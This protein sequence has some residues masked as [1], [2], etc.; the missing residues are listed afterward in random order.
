MTKLRIPRIRLW[1]LFAFVTLAA[2]LLGLWPKVSLEVDHKPGIGSRGAIGWNS[3]EP[4]ELWNT[5][6]LPPKPPPNLSR[7][8]PAHPSM[9]QWRRDQVRKLEPREKQQARLDEIRSRF[10]NHP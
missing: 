8:A 4:F 2:M 1:H 5:F 10:S 3:G 7:F 6:P 9:V